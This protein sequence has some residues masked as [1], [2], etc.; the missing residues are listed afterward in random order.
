MIDFTA[1]AAYVKNPSKAITFSG[2]E[3][4]IDKISVIKCD[5]PFV[6]IEFDSWEYP[7]SYK[8]API[9]IITDM[10]IA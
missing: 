1:N 8:G 10:S 3:T 2:W 4:N 5:S 7:M 6:P 9:S